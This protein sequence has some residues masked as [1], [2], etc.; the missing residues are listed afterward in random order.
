MRFFECDRECVGISTVLSCTPSQIR[1][2]LL[3]LS[4]GEVGTFVGVES[5]AETTFESSEMVTKDVG[6]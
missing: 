1:L 2:M 4:M 3:S 5:E 6:I